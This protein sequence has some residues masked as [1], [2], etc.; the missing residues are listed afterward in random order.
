MS[1]SATLR[2]VA[3]Q[4]LLSMGFSRQEYRRWLP[5]PSPGDLPDPGIKSVSFMVPCWQVGSLSLHGLCMLCFLKIFFF[6]VFC[7]VLLLSPNFFSS[8]NRFQVFA[9][10]S[11]WVNKFLPSGVSPTASGLPR[12]FA[13]LK[14]TLL[15]LNKPLLSWVYWAWD[16]KGYLGCRGLL[17]LLEKAAAA[18]KSF[19]LIPLLPALEVSLPCS[20][21]GQELWFTPARG[22]PG[23]ALDRRFPHSTQ[24]SI[25]TQ[26]LNPSV[27]LRTIIH[28]S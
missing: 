3:H 24:N 25:Y 18:G 13:F 26:I 17:E 6:S 20:S 21:G 4:A 2:A 22:V 8:I 9:W 10:N 15:H 5:V 27:C 7:L 19:P 11:F 12:L 23:S 28:S 14:R 16:S 1:D